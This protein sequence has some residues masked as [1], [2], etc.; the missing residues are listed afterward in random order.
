MCERAPFNEGQRFFIALLHFDCRT[1]GLASGFT[2]ALNYVLNFISTKTYY[3][4]ETSLSLPGFTL[5]S[6]IVIMIGWILAFAILPE[7]E[8]RTLEDIELHFSD[9]SKKLTNHKIP[10]RRKIVHDQDLN[11]I[12]TRAT[13]INGT[14]T[15]THTAAVCYDNSGFVDIKLW[16]LE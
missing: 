9:K 11:E 7:T 3:N 1:R 5:L 12:S 15:A 13:S 8:G 10:K 16:S 2:A 14:T 6:C 4:L